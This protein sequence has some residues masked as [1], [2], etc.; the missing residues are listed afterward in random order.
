MG[1][2]RDAAGGLATLIV[3]A[4]SGARALTRDLRRCRDYGLRPVGCLDDDPRIRSVSGIPVL[5]KLS[6]LRAVVR[7][8]QIEAIIIAIPSLRRASLSRLVREAADTGAPRPLPALVP[9][10]GE[11]AARAADMRTVRLSELLG[12]TERQV[13]QP[14]V[15][16]A[17]AGARVLITG[18]GG[19]IGRNCA[20]EVR[21]QD[22]AVAAHAGSR[23]VQSASRCSSNCR[24]VRC[25]TTPR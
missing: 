16:A 5:G 9:V 3:G 25:W 24:G 23:P 21:S 6:D 2:D 1:Q 18:A 13:I 11:R 4:G 8:Y 15:Q 22:P 20:G 12:R 17:L 10:G 19:S 14:S 7:T